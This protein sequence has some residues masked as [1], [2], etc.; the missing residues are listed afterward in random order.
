[1]SRKPRCPDTCRDGAIL[2]PRAG[3]PSCGTRH[4]GSV[5]SVLAKQVGYQTSFLL[6]SAGGSSGLSRAP[7]K[8]GMASLAGCLS[9]R[10]LPIALIGAPFVVV[11][12][13]S[14]RGASLRAATMGLLPAYDCLRTAPG[15]HPV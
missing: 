9:H 12:G 1:M 2:P 10:G 15:H 14:V 6:S 13:S 3:A 4:L 5:R 7:P 8:C 11:A